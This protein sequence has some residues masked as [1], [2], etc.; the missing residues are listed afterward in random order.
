MLKRLLFIALFFLPTLAYATPITP[1]TTPGGTTAWLVESHTLPMI[2]VE[3]AFRA[4]AAFDPKGQE[5][6]ST[7]TAGLMTEAVGQLD[8]AALAAALE[9]LGAHMTSGSDRLNVTVTLSVLSENIAPAMAL[10]ADALAHP[11]FTEADTQRVK[12]AML[13]DI[14]QAMENP[15]QVASRE[16]QK[17]LYGTHP[18]AHPQNGTKESVST[19]TTADVK[20]FYRNNITRANMAISVVGDI[21]PDALKPLLDKTLADL[22]PGTSRNKMQAM[23][24]P[25]A[26]ATKRLPLDAPQ[27]TII[28]THKGIDRKEPDFFPTLMM[29]YILG[30]GGFGTRLMEEVREK[31]GLAYGIYS[32]FQPLPGWGPFTI[33][34][35][36]KN[37]SVPE[38]LKLIHEN[39]ARIQK[40]GVTEKE[41]KDAMDYLVGSFPLRLDSN[42]NILGYLTFMQTEN[43]GIDYLDTWVARMQAVTREQVNKA[44]QTR[45]HPAQLITVIVGP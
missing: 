44:A 41:Y 8:S 17:L 18:Y 9:R 11:A 43:L 21:T 34:V 25:G 37:E 12:D 36:T 6:L 33:T 30:G 40:D 42:A 2:S 28:L 29:N 27:S 31:R 35:Q 4:G 5:G 20:T 1:V 19:L 10:L 26:P 22:A 23:P 39:L 3:V 14:Q 24:T 45:L 16:A 7:L 38:V 32:M 15:A 13:A